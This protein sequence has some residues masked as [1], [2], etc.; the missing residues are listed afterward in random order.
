MTHK[1]FSIFFCN[2]YA[3]VYPILTFNLRHLLMQLEKKQLAA[4]VFIAALLFIPF[5]GSVHLFDWDEVNFAESAREMIETGNYS[6]VQINYQPFWEKPPLFFWLQVISMKLFGINEFAARFPN[7][8]C[9]IITLVCLFH[10]G[11]KAFSQ[12]FATWWVIIYAGSFL[13]HLY[14]KSGIIDPW[15][16]LFI[17]LGVYYLIRF[18]HCYHKRLPLMRPLV[19]SALFTGLGILTKG[20][21]ALLLVMLSYM[22]YLVFTKGK[23]IAKLVHYLIYAGV[24]FLVSM[25]WFGYELWQNGIWFIR[26]F[27]DY[28]IRLMATEES[29]HGGPIYYHLVVLLLGV[30]PASV[31]IYKIKRSASENSF[32]HSLQNM[33]LSSLIVVVVVFSLVQT[34]I[35]H[36]SSFAYFPIT[37]LAAYTVYYVSERGRRIHTPQKVLIGFIGM[38]WAILGIAVPVVGLNAKKLIPLIEDEFAAGNLEAAVNWS[39]LHAVPGVLYGAMIVAVLL[40]F[41][42]RRY[43]KAFRVLF[44]GTLIYV[45][46]IS[47]VFVPKIERYTQNA[48]IEFLKS[49]QGKDVYVET[50]GYK[51]YAQYY[52]SMRKP[53][54]RPEG[55]D[56]EWLLTGTPDKPA[57][58]ICR[59]YSLADLQEK[60]G[61]RLQELYRKNGFVFFKRI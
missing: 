14:F 31:L 45:Q 61:S 28:Q 22:L 11:R 15:F 41:R 29:G 50:W 47:L 44:I 19:L 48:A 52:Y 10:I 38:K 27:Y 54:N 43:Q 8:I 49:L 9:G 35:V 26:E 23:G 1:D 5:L 40:M 30:F 51:S 20:P 57:Y 3:Y 6:R 53:G 16:N 56:I 32:Q 46:Y 37:F 59:M 60:H 13:P 33:M 18:L 36:Y 42:K 24:V 17:F 58:I 39:F 34:K 55:S 12:T 7:A 21:V 4:I 25:V 2:N